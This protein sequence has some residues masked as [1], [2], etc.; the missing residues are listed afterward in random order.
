MKKDLPKDKM[1]WTA[2]P[3]GRGFMLV[4]SCC[5]LLAKHNGR[6]PDSKVSHVT[7]VAMADLVNTNS[8]SS[9]LSTPAP[10]QQP[11]SSSTKITKISDVKDIKIPSF[12]GGGDQFKA[13]TDKVEHC[14]GELVKTLRACHDV[15]RL[16]ASL[17]GNSGQKTGAHI[18]R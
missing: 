3:F 7:L 2:V 9:R 17:Q 11:T 1:P 8:L 13:W 6:L 14:L 15:I 12:S 4:V 16:S 18:K 5:K 10:L